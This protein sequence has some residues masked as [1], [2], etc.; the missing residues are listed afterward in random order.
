[1]KT[2]EPTAILITGITV[3]PGTRLTI[4]GHQATNPDE[5]TKEY[6]NVI[7][8]RDQAGLLIKNFA[9]VN[10]STNP[11]SVKVSATL[12]APQAR[13]QLTGLT[14]PGTFVI[15]TEG[16]NT[17]G[18]DLAGPT[19]YFSKLFPAITP[20]DHKISLY[21]V[22]GDDLATSVIPLEIYA[23]VYQLTTISNLLLSPTITINTNTILQGDPLIATGSAFPGAQITLFTDSP[24]KTYTASASAAGV[25]TKTL[26]DTADY[27]PGDYRI[28]SLGQNLSTGLQSL[29]SPSLLFSVTTTGGGGGTACGNIAHGDINCDGGINLTDFSI[30]MYYWGTANATADI[31]T[32][33]TVDLIDFSIMMYYW[34]T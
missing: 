9:N 28:Y 21:G 31:N 25:W 22:D 29:I 1:V 30:L 4:E 19:G 24:L 10:I 32:D 13:L 33:S 17:I 3:L 26:T 15:F 11:G 7:I 23:P 34:G 16:G 8:T 2:L 18:S 27:N 5:V 14:G 12:N 6:I 20:N